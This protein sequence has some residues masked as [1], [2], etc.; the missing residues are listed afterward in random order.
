MFSRLTIFWLPLLFLGPGLVSALQANPS[1]TFA[2]ANKALAEGSTQDAVHLYEVLVSNGYTSVD[3]H[4]NLGT[5]YAKLG[6]TVQARLNLEKAKYLAPDDPDISRNLK[7]VRDEIGDYYT[8]PQYPLFGALGWT[9]THLGSNFWGWTVLL[10]F[11][12]LGGL[13]IGYRL[14]QQ[15][16]LKWPIALSGALIL[17]CIP[18]LIASMAYERFHSDMVLLSNSGGLIEIP[19][20][21]GKIV[22]E[23]QAGAKLHIEE[24]FGEWLRVSSATGTQ[25][26]LTRSET[27]KVI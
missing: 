13:I 23:L 8:F 10:L 12:I 14:F 1:D 6:E 5:A 22:E 20:E 7:L 11:M 4:Y 26:W 24:E 25:G 2:L 21:S 15:S 17:C 27:I 18:F 9:R 16:R 3:L 19:E